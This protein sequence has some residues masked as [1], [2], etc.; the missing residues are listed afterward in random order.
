MLVTLRVERVNKMLTKIDGSP[1]KQNNEKHN[2][3]RASKVA[4]ESQ[5]ITAM[6]SVSKA[7]AHQVDLYA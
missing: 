5:I 7:D 2:N 1:A 6:L 4:V 3:R